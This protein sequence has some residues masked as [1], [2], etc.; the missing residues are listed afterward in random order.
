MNF[1]EHWDRLILHFDLRKNGR[2]FC[3]SQIFFLTIHLFINFLTT[4]RRKVINEYQFG[5]DMDLN[6]ENFQISVVDGDIFILEYA[7][8]ATLLDDALAEWVV[9]KCSN[10]QYEQITVFEH[11]EETRVN[12]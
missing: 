12:F 10:S 3:C 11:M 9:T 7:E 4:N 8:S 5:S 2:K 1:E 6:D